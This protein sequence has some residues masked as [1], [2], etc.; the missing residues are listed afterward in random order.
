MTLYPALYTA[1]PDCQSA[2]SEHTRPPVTGPKSAVENV[3]KQSSICYPG[4]HCGN[5]STDRRQGAKTEAPLPRGGPVFERRKPRRRDARG[6]RQGLAALGG[7]VQERG[8]GGM[9]P[10]WRALC[11]GLH[12]MHRERSFAESLVDRKQP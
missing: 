12:D 3:Q 11:D 10:F 6:D 4:Y 1:M 8:H 2:P 9:K 7:F 5:V